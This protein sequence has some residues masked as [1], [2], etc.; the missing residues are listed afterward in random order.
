MIWS[1][2][3]GWIGVDVGTH[4]VKLAQLEKR[5]GTV[6]LVDALVVRRSQAWQ[7]GDAGSRA[8]PWESIREIRAG[9]A[10][11]KKFRGRDAA[12]SL[13][14]AV[15][16]VRECQVPTDS[17]EGPRWE[18]VAQELKAAWGNTFDQR[19][20][21]FWNADLPVG[22]P[23]SKETLFAF[24]IPGSWSTR[25]V[26]DMTQSGL[27]GLVL[28]G[29]PL[30]LARAVQLGGDLAGGSVLAVE[31]GCPRAS[32]CGVFAG[33]PYYVRCLRGGGFDDVIQSLRVAMSLTT[34]EAEKLLTEHGLAD[35]GLHPRSK[36]QAVIEDVITEPL[37]G[38]VH[39]LKRTLAFLRQ[40]RRGI[41]HQKMI[42]LGGGACL[43][44]V[45]PFLTDKLVLPVEVWQPDVE[46]MQ[47]GSQPQLPIELFGPAMALSSLRWNRG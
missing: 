46:R 17:S 13:P 26:K 38:F 2:T 22:Q 16:D 32:L 15:C 28:D 45:A 25:V 6:R 7:V 33:H 40:H 21:E 24:S 20:L 39:E 23:K 44:N 8:G 10:L 1:R 19:E 27:D 36:M 47:H 14:M 18:T 35:C 29:L 30:A 3:R 11:S 9:L 41:S 43:R 31:W 12:V 37:E 34:E 4:T 42:L 5:A